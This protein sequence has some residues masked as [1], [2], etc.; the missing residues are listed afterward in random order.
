L[1]VSAKSQPPNCH[2]NE[3]DMRQWI[4]MIGEGG[5]MKPT[6]PARDIHTSLPWYGLETENVDNA[7][8]KMNQWRSYDG[9]EG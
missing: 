4:R 3:K 7:E 2:I 1:G 5:K 8:I 6:T 9:V